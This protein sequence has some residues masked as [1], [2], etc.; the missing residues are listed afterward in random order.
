MNRKIVLN[1]TLLAFALS[2]CDRSGHE[3]S[4]VRQESP[5]PPQD[6]VPAQGKP[7]NQVGQQRSGEY[8]L[9]LFNETGTVK[10]GA[11]RFVLEVRNAATNALTPVEQIHIETSMEMGG[12]PPMIGRGSAVAGDAP[13]RY[14]IGSDFASKPPIGGDTS[15]PRERQMAGLWKLVVIFHPNERIEFSASVSE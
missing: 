9:T 10:Q 14:I 1:L 4:G 13:G 3:E 6:T 11:N 12:H 8:I 2:A 5:A 7:L 15:S